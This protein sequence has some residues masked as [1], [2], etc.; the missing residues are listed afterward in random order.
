[1][2]LTAM[3]PTVAAERLDSF[4]A[5]CTFLSRLFLRPPDDHLIA[6]VADA[7]LWQQ[8]PLHRDE[9]TE[10]G[11]AGMHQAVTGEDRETVEELARD[12]Q[13]LFVG[14]AHVIACPYESVYLSDEHLIFE[15]QTLA[16]RHFYARFG[17]Q[18]PSLNREP[19]DHLGLEL[20]FLARLSVLGLD[21]LDDGDL[22]SVGAVTDAI[23][24]FLTEH[25]LRWVFDCLERLHVGANTRFYRGVSLL[26]E[27]AVHQLR[28]AFVP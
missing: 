12:Y 3:A 18:A 15:E 22:E 17:L 16:V 7:D 6:S 11:L 25:L 9:W 20:D 13:R 8:W 5:A 27:G 1:M 23:G 19:D 24:Q 4:G 28:M 10:R 2:T 21:A 26:T 14:P